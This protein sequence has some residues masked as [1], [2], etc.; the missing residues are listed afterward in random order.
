MSISEINKT[1]IYEFWY[2]YIKPKYGKLDIW[3]MVIRI[4]IALLFILKLKI[5]KKILLMMLKNGLIHQIMSVIDHS[6]KGKTR[7]KLEK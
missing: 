5:F 2:D 6:V 7:K 4:E 1:L 3:I